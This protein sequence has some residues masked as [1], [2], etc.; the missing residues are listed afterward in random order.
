MEEQGLGPPRPIQQLPGPQLARAR[1]PPSE[2]LHGRLL[3]SPP[4]PS[5]PIPPGAPQP[6]RIQRLLRAPAGCVRAGPAASAG[7]LRASPAAAVRRR[8]RRPGLA[9]VSASAW[10]AAGV[11]QC[12]ASAECL[13]PRPT[14]SV[15]GGLSSV[16][17]LVEWGGYTRAGVSAEAGV[18]A[19]AKGG[20]LP[21]ETRLM[22]LSCGL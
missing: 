6:A 11:W 12:A 5:R 1:R 22:L 18:S 9:A 15:A 19:A 16:S 21:C 13:W 3:R 10:W 7:W 17:L 2:P 8:C 14:G 20:F 4:R